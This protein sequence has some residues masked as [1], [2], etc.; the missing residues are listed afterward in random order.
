[1]KKEQATSVSIIAETKH[2]LAVDK[3]A[4]QSVEG[5]NDR[6]DTTESRLF[7]YLATQ[8]NNPYV[9]IVHRLDRVTSGVL[10]VAKRKSALKK[11]NKAFAQ[12]QVEKTYL[13]IVHKSPESAKGTLTHWLEKDQLQK[14][15]ILH[16][17]PTKVA[18]EVIL[19]YEV[20]QKT[21]SYTLLKIEPKTGKFHQIRAQLAAIDCPIIGDEKYGSESVYEENAIALHAYQLAFPY[22]DLEDEKIKITAQLPNTLLWRQFDL[23]N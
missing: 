18:K 14:R 2:W 6:Y 5:F 4:G 16:I 7:D 22:P 23:T 12:R 17:A 11:L 10:L 9:G 3:L 1:M 20:M 19:N 13:A 8:Y 15:A 21:E